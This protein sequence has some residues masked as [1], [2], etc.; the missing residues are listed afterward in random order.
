MP[1]DGVFFALKRIRDVQLHVFGRCGHWAQ[2]EQ[3]VPFNRIV[4]NF[5][6]DP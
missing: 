4:S 5:L 6:L 3:T 2:M 1:L